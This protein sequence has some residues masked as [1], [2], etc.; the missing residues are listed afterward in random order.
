M[1]LRI[2][3][4]LLIAVLEGR[5]TAEIEREVELA[6]QSEP[7]V[8]MRMEEL[9][10]AVHWPLGSAPVVT[11]SISESLH[12]A[13]L[14]LEQDWDHVL[15]AHSLPSSSSSPKSGDNKPA[16]IPSVRIVREIGR[17]GMGVVYEG[18]DEAL[19]RRVAIKQLHPQYDR[20]IQA[21]ERL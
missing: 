3:D 1:S 19:G 14:R 5:A 6:I 12:T 20:D 9:S 18:F 10:G 15:A 7:S 16:E 17:G 11:P 4:D 8:R 2:D 13:I 21:K